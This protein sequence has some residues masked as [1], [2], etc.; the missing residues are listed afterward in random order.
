[1][2]CGLLLLFCLVCLFCALGVSVTLCFYFAGCLIDGVVVGVLV[3][4]FRLGVVCS[5]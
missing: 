3:M 4:R 1:M 5:V 2:L